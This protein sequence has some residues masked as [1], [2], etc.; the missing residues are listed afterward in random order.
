MGLYGSLNKSTTVLTYCQLV[1]VPDLLKLLL[2]LLLL[3]VNNTVVQKKALLEM[4]RLFEMASSLPKRIE[5]QKR[6]R[7][8]RRQAFQSPES[9]ARG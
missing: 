7:R 9:L 3:Q 5:A 4:T 1:A 2:P 6:R 8:R